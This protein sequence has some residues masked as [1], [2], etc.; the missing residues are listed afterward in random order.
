[1]SL[2]RIYS[3]IARPHR[4]D[5]LTIACALCALLMMPITASAG[6]EPLVL[7]TPL[8]IQLDLPALS[9]ASV[10]ETFLSEGVSIWFSATILIFTVCA[11]MLAV[12]YKPLAQGLK[13]QLSRNGFAWPARFH[14]LQTPV[15]HFRPTRLRPDLD[16]RGVLSHSTDAVIFTNLKQEIQFLNPA[17]ES[18]LGY[19]AEELMG[20]PLTVIHDNSALAR[21]EKATPDEITAHASQALYDKP[22]RNKSGVLFIGETL[23]TQAKDTHGTLIGYVGTIRDVTQRREAEQMLR[24]REHHLNCLDQVSRAIAQYSDL[25]TMITSAV[26]EILKVFRADRAWLINPCDPQA[27][28]W[29]VMVEATAGEQVSDMNESAE[30]LMTDGIAHL[31][32]R[33]L[34]TRRALT[35]YGAH[36]PLDM[37][38][39][40]SSTST[41]HLYIAIF[42]KVGAPWL[43]S[44]Q[45]HTYKR[46]WNEE[47]K[48]LLVDLSDRLRDTLTQQLLL[49][50]LA[51]DISRR[52][53]IEQSLHEREVLYH[54]I[55]QNSAVALWGQDYTMVKHHLDLLKHN[56]V[57]DMKTYLEEN[58]D[59]VTLMMRQIKPLEANQAS[60]SLFSA[61]HTQVLAQSLQKLLA[62]ASP[63]AFRSL[64]TAIAEAQ[65]HFVAESRFVALDGRNI[66]T[67][68]HL[69]LPRDDAGY[70]HLPVSFVDITEQKLSEEK[71]GL[72]AAVF[73]N[74]AEGV[75]ICDAELNVIALNRSFSEITG[76]EEE[77]VVSRP[78]HLFENLR[79]D[80]RQYNSIWQAVEQTGRWQGDAQDIRKQGQAYPVWLSISTIK[81]SKG[82][83]TRYVIVFDDI[84]ALKQSQAQLDHLAYHDPLTQL[85]NRTLFNDRLGQALKRAQ[86]TR[87]Q[88]GLLFIDL[89]RFKDVNDAQ[90]HPVGDLL[91]KDV[92]TRL[93]DCLRGSDSVARLGGDEF[94]IILE[95]LSDKTTVQTFARKLLTCVSAPCVLCDQEAYITASIGI[96]L[97]P[98]HGSD[99]TTLI[100]NADTAMYKAKDLGRNNFQIFK[101]ALSDTAEQRYS[102]DNDLRRALLNDEFVLYYQP[103]VDCNSGALLGAETLIRWQHPSLGLI[104]PDD[105]IPLAEESG[106]IVPLGEW[107]LQTACLQAASWASRSANA[108]KLKIAVNLSATQVSTR[109][110]QVVPKILS[111]SRLP[112]ELLELEITESLMMGNEVENIAIL[113]ALE[114]AGISLS[115]D[116][117]GTGY[118]SLSYLKRIP[119]NNVK[120][121]RS[122]VKDLASD[123]EDVAIVSTIIAMAKCLN[124]SVTAEGVENREQLNL[125]RNMGCDKF[126]GFLFGKP[127][128]ADEFER[129]H[130]KIL[131]EGPSGSLQ[132]LNRPKRKSTTAD[133]TGVQQNPFA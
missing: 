78:C 47:D 120:I 36:C 30:L 14:T 116:D 70:A 76:Y 27:P 106:L 131:D 102:L 91:L 62:S 17:A 4:I 133:N 98:E 105:F 16:L 124:H 101:Q 13:I 10:Q 79:K 54:S 58:P 121:D 89:D 112:P 113:S 50:R 74:T 59:T 118:S 73:E 24:Q 103:Q 81:N 32:R 125:L 40:S 96:S 126:Q 72:A 41:S 63:E 25:S 86:A 123:A 21:L 20:R 119:L 57:E 35:H 85:P 33:A 5:A 71:I 92:A 88:V 31:M 18:L 109:L 19:C 51:Q 83:I 55:F 46:E 99:A 110:L 61:A 69:T 93:Q 117:F 104:M 130:L 3:L 26:N 42:P 115:I 100:K 56:G 87:K 11:F 9:S 75:C 39:S 95:D 132:V 49:E 7:D 97:F 127:M 29:R 67:L 52:E 128:P 23:F 77:D 43:L 66:T 22:Y 1:M 111:A 15:K 64:F 53:S 65:E 2:S 34:N 84:S 45:Q 68:M 8:S 108:S 60:L 12:F 107:I 82:A 37:Y 6:I 44:L 129:H 114:K 80:W 122:F 28:S 38:A 48:R 90:G 94:A